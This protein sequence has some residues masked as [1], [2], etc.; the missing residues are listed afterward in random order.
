VHKRIALNIEAIRLWN[1]NGSTQ[2][3]HWGQSR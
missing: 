2:C 3:R 1:W